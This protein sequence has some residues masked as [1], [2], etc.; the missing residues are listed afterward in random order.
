MTE[1]LTGRSEHQK[2]HPYRPDCHDQ[3]PCSVSNYNSMIHTLDV[4]QNYCLRQYDISTY[5][6][7]FFDITSVPRAP[8]PAPS[9]TQVKDIS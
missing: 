1:I 9:T 8:A 2:L 4:P 3:C 7:F 5:D 6:T